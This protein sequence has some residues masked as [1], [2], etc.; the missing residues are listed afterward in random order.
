MPRVGI[1]QARDLGDGGDAPDHTALEIDVHEAV[2]RGRRIDHGHAPELSGEAP[3]GRKIAADAHGRAAPRPSRPRPGLLDSGHAEHDGQ[4][5][6]DRS[7]HAV[8]A[9]QGGEPPRELQVD[10]GNEPRQPLRG[11]PIGLRHHD[12]EPDGGGPP[13]PITSMSRARSVRGQGH[14]P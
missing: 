6:D 12:V 14:C 10:A 13:R 4:S 2:A 1:E 8:I 11:Q 3:A 7:E 5:P 9:R